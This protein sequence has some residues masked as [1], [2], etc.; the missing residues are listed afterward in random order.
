M[1]ERGKGMQE[2]GSRGEVRER[3]LGGEGRQEAV[4]EGR[5]EVVGAGVGIREE[6]RGEARRGKGG[7]REKRRRIEEEKKGAEG[8]DDGD[9]KCLVMCN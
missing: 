2:S 8:S 4:G 1:R 6:R 3:G 9:A 5:R 7:V